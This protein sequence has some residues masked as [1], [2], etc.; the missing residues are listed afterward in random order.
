MRGSKKNPKTPSTNG[1][2]RAR[3]RRKR[4]TEPDFVEV[5]RLRLGR[6]PFRAAIPIH[7]DRIRGG[8]KKLTIKER[9]IKLRQFAPIF[10]GFKAAGE[11]PTT[12]PRQIERKAVQLFMEWLK[13][14]VPDPGSQETYLNHLN[15]FLKSFKNFVIEEMKADGFRFPRKVKKPIRS[16]DMKGIR[17]VLKAAEGMRGWNGSVSK[18]LVAIYLATGVRVSELR[19]AHFDDLDLKGMTLYV[20]N[21]KGLGS[22]ASPEWVDILRPELVPLIKE[23]LI[24]REEYLNRREFE[25]VSPLFPHLLEGE[26]IFYSLNGLNS[27]KRKIEEASGV[28]FRLKDLRPTHASMEVNDNLSRLNAV[29][30]QLRHSTPETTA[31]F[32]AKVD[33]GRAVR[34]QLS[35][36]WRENPIFPTENPVIDKKNDYTGYV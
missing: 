35:E 26:M 36:V 5:E 12:D 4:P 31:K 27:I 19:L 18:G 14:E 30:A 28:S 11:I 32:Y 21:P 2:R 17:A 6:Y 29:S 16:L 20:R 25:K 10:E 33:R 1:V 23:Y 3:K 8:V 9:G 15:M 7:L 22:Y 24:E 13:E 34:K